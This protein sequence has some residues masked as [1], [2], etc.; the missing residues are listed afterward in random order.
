[1]E[2]TFYS[3]PIFVR[4]TSISASWKIKNRD[5]CGFR[6]HTVVDHD[7]HWRILPFTMMDAQ[8]DG[9][10]HLAVREIFGIEIE[11]DLWY[12]SDSG[13]LRLSGHD[14]IIPTRGAQKYIVHTI[15]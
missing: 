6:P 1:M 7:C 14:G 4:I 8:D 15:Y 3:E 11:Q 5:Y 10:D 12:T 9:R 2:S 13:L